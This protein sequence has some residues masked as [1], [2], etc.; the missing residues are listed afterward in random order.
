MRTV[1]G[2]PTVLPMARVTKRSVL[3]LFLA[4]CSTFLPVGRVEAVYDPVDGTV[5]SDAPYAVVVVITPEDE[6]SGTLLICTGALTSADIVVTAAHCVHG[7]EARAVT[8]VVRNADRTDGAVH[9]VLGT[10]IH[11]NYEPWRAAAGKPVTDDLALLLLA[12]RVRKV[13]PIALAPSRDASLRTRLEFFGWG[14]DS[15]GNIGQT[16]GKALQTDVTFTETSP[17]GPLDTDKHILARSGGGEPC[18]GDSGGPLV[19]FRKNSTKPVLV[20]VMSYRSDSCGDGNP[21][22]HTRV[23]SYR[24]WF[25]AASR[26]LRQ[27]WRRR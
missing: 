21:V 14:K 3:P 5:P 10:S 8:V 2:A 23:A 17:F 4:V 19:G 12:E 22:V 15:A 13:R 16:F 7:A 26:E 25:S 6:T 1:G 24:K 11:P 18:Y 27:A 9:Q 20:G